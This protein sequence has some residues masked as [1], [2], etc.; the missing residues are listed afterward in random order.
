MFSEILLKPFTEKELLKSFK[1]QHF[2]QHHE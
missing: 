1:L 2:T